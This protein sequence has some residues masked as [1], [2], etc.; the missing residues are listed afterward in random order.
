MEND[1]A[2]TVNI[3][4]VCENI[5]L[6]PDLF[7]LLNMEKYIGTFVLWICLYLQTRDA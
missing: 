2:T 5:H 3:S 4:L 1:V 6:K 7:F